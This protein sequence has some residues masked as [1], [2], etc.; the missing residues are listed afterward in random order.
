MKRVI[1]VLILIVGLFGIYGCSSSPKYVKSQ[2]QN[3]VNN[4]QIKSSTLKYPSLNTIEGSDFASFE[5]AK[6]HFDK[7]AVDIH[8]K[9]NS[10]EIEPINQYGINEKPKAILD[11]IAAFMLKHPTLKVRIEGNCDERGTVE[12]NLALGQ[13]RALAAK[14]YLVAKGVNPDRIDIISYGESRPLDPA[15]NEYA[16]AKNRRDHF[17]LLER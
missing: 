14:K 7:V 2:S 16:W 5:D 17:V 8:F 13:K 15:H 6:K 9:F 12:Y 10:F 4:P 11:R 1:I 3:E